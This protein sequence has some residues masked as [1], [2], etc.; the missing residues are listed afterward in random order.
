MIVVS[1]RERRPR[2]G[3]EA[4]SRCA[5]SRIARGGRWLSNLQEARALRQTVTK[6]FAD[7]GLLGALG[8][9]SSDAVPVSQRMFMSGH[10][11]DGELRVTRAAQRL[12]AL[13]D[14]GLACRERGGAD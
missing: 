5:K 12:D 1:P 14:L 9:R 6:P 2:C 4:H 10:E 11:L 13:L 8:E 7:S 3:S